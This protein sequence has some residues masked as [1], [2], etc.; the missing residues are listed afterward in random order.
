ML[1]AC[2]ELVCRACQWQ[3]CWLLG[4]GHTTCAEYTRCCRVLLTA[5]NGRVQAGLKPLTKSS[6][7]MCDLGDQ[8]GVLRQFVEPA[9]HS[10]IVV[11]A[12]WSTLATPMVTA[13]AHR[14][15]PRHVKLELAVQHACSVLYGASTACTEL[16]QV[17]GKKCYT[18]WTSFHLN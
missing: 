15:V 14:A 17:T 9:N 2:P 11:V 16:R 8:V 10:L 6:W 12:G 4:P 3:G 1:V 13:A 5:S 7:Q 18:I